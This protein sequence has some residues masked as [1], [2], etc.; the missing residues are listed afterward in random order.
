MSP[1]RCFAVD[2]R[3]TACSGSRGL[4][5]AF[6]LG[7]ASRCA[8]LR[9]PSFAHVS[10]VAAK[11]PSMQALDKLAATLRLSL[12]SGSLDGCACSLTS[13]DTKAAHTIEDASPLSHRCRSLG[14]PQAA[15]RGGTRFVGPRRK[16][17]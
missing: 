10:A 9:I 5:C 13:A 15:L 2:S 3:H 16:K 8:V 12:A 7:D 1:S 4:H 17:S 6:P 11:G 14:W